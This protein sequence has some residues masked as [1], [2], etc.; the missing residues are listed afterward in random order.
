MKDGD[1]SFC[2]THWQD[3]LK[4]EEVQRI[5]REKDDENKDGGGSSICSSMAVI[6]G[7]LGISESYIFIH[8]YFRTY[9]C[10]YF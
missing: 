10:I 3:F 9:F 6:E 4:G 7:N 2:L 8:F 1:V 5:F